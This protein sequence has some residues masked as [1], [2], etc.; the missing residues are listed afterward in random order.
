MPS[1]TSPSAIRANCSRAN[2][3]VRGEP[4]GAARRR[5]GESELPAA[6]DLDLV[7]V[8]HLRWSATSKSVSRSTASPKAVDA[9]SVVARRGEQVDDP[10]A[11]RE[12]AAVLDLVLPPVAGRDEIGDEP[13]GVDLAAPA[14]DDR[15]RVADRR[16]EPLQQR[17]DGRHDEERPR[18]LPAAGR[19]AAVR[20]VDPPDR[21]Q[22]TPH[23][24][25]RGRYPL[26]R[27][28]LPGG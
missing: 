24:L 26:E 18:R 16:G 23:G 1:K 11:H 28:G 2:G 12:L 4:G 8:A 9:H 15:R 20:P 14:D 19:I 17:V 3:A 6:E 21:P 13:D 5:L 7:E 10:A 27:Q 25:R 22:T